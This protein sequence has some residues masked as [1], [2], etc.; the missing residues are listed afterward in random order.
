MAQLIASMF[1][2]VLG[3]VSEVV[4]SNLARGKTF[5]VSIGS[6]DL[7]YPSTQLI[8][9]FLKYIYIYIYIKYLYI[10]RSFSY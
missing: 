4:G 7:L 10:E 1:D 3:G 8:M 9:T 5:T 2:V 6:V